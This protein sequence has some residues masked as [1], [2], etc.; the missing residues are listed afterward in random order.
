MLVRFVVCVLAKVF[1]DYFPLI[2]RL[3]LII[4]HFLIIFDFL[5]FDFATA[6]FDFAK[7]KL[8]KQLLFIF[9]VHKC[10]NSFNCIKTCTFSVFYRLPIHF[11]CFFIILFYSKTIFIA[12]S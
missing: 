2:L 4:S 5:L 7:S 11:Y 8:I 9:L 1:F 10:I 6:F 3:I 12:Y